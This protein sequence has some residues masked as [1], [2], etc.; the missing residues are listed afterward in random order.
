MSRKKLNA[1]GGRSESSKLEAR[2]SKEARSPN[3]ET[4]LTKVLRLPFGIRFSDFFRI[5]ALATLLACVFTAQLAIAERRFPPPD[6]QSGHQLPVTTTPA[7]RELWLQYT[8]VAVLVVALA[9]ASWI[10]LRLRSR[11][12]MIW[13]SVSSMLYFGFYRKGCICPIGAPQNVVLALFSSSYTV[14]L[15][16]LAFF[17]L[18]LVAALFFG[19]SF[20]AAVCPHG[21]IQDLVLVKPVTLPRWL[22][23]ALGVLPYAFLGLG[24]LFAATGSAFIIC[25][26]DPFVPIFRRTGSFTILLTGAA[27]LLVGMFV[28]RPYCRFLCPYG[29]LLKLAGKV[30]KWRVLITPNICTQCKLC[31]KACPFGAIREPSPEPP[32]RS[33]LTLE[34]KRFTALAVALPVLI[35]IAGWAGSKFAVAASGLDPQVN[36]AERH[37]EA[38]AGEGPQE[39]TKPEQVALA[40]AARTESE[41]MPAAIAARNHL[42]LGGWILGGGFGLFVGLRLFGFSIWTR[43]VDWEPDAGDCVAC[44]RCFRSCPQELIR[45]GITPPEM[46]QPAAV[47]AAPKSVQG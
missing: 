2:N 24:L 36:L 45:L 13:L 43:R 4:R 40:R 16:A 31:E 22:E 30:S 9:A 19:R 21:A 27:F 42:A 41:L 6:F 3:A 26:W 7:A 29:A 34:R 5:S 1:E 38:K 25:R 23:Q 32:P 47:P 37:L 20:C 10:A 14:P 17:L 33:A 46:P 35:L 12:A 8:D 11:R 44:A 28:G 15:T 39:P 18:P